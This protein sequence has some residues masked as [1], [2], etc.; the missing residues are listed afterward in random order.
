MI[1]AKTTPPNTMWMQILLSFLL[2]TGCNMWH[3]GPFHSEQCSTMNCCTATNA[4]N[5]NLCC[6][7]EFLLQTKKLKG[8]HAHPLLLGVRE[9][10][11]MD[12]GNVIVGNKPYLSNFHEVEK[13]P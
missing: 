12:S 10:V 6:Q 2:A 9:I 13:F 5:V 7:N 4:A 11:C 8:S 1:T 3:P